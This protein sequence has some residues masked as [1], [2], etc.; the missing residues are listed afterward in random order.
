[1]LGR[2]VTLGERRYTIVGVMPAD[3]DYPAG[4]DVWAPTHSVPTD[5]PFGDAARREIDLV[6][7]LRAGTTMVEATAALQALLRHDEADGGLRGSVANVRRFEDAIVGAARRPLLA[8]FAAVAL[9]LFVA[10]ANVAN[11]QL[12]RMEGR[13]GELAVHAALGAGRARLVRQVA[14]EMLMLAAAAT[15]HR[16]AGRLVG[17]PR[18]RRGAAGWSSTRRRDRHGRE[19]RR[20]RRRAALADDRD[21]VAAGGA[22]RR[23]PVA[24]RRARVG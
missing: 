21:R 22:A 13:R 5:G 20:L 19:R 11:L 17:R 8:L 10:C 3:L 9:V 1:M 2:R 15:A 6:A 18:P 23:P 24:R 16:G 7:R 14:L 12:M 4:V